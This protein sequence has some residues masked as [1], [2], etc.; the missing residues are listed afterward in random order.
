MADPITS[1]EVA[2]VLA[3]DAAIQRASG[4]DGYGLLLTGFVPKPFPRLLA[5]KLAL[6]QTIFGAQVDLTSGSTIR[7]LLE[8]TALE[9][10]RTWAALAGT[11]DSIF[12]SS[13]IG[14]ALSRLGRELGLPRPWLEARGSVKVKLVEALPA[15]A[16]QI[17]IPRGARLSTPGG[18]HVATTESITLSAS[19]KER[20]VPIAAFYPGPEHNLNPAV[21]SQKIDRWHRLDPALKPLVDAEAAASATLVAIEHTVALTGGERQWPDARFRELLLRAPRSVWTI[22]SVETAVSMVPGVRQVSV[23]DPMGGLD[24]NQSIFGNFNFIERLFSTERDVASPYYF[25]VLVA[26][27]PAA[28]WEGP[29]GLQATIESAIEDLRPI[30]IFP[31]VTQAD[32]VG[33]GVQAQLVVEGIPLPSG[34]KQKVNESRAA[35]ELKRRLLDRVGRYIDG[36]RFGEPVRAAEITW[37]MMNEPGI[38]DVVNLRLRRFPSEFGSIQFGNAVPPGTV[39]LP[40][41]A[42]LPLQSQQIAVLVDDAAGLEII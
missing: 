14:D 11:Y 26:P 31:N 32:Q 24:I 42:N 4:A 16:A 40:P 12:V 33:V 28:I 5:E 8:I 35:E 37:A 38:A 1:V 6:A 41:N 39:V 29:D 22:G 15:G 10:A 20:D 9:D 3:V 23:R 2:D 18:H 34:S 13:A 19:S 17:T 25:T 36:L 27:A 7:K 21:P 30:G